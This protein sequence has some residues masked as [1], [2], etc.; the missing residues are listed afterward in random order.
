M[1][2]NS[3]VQ[4]RIDDVMTCY[5]RHIRKLFSELGIEVT[6][7][8]KREIDKKIHEVLG[9]EYKNCSVTWRAFKEARD[10]DSSF[11]A[12]LEAALSQF[13]K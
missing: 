9:V 8:N 12:R 1:P 6:E 13:K 11:I 10:T 3:A 4:I 5:F 2:L 7:E